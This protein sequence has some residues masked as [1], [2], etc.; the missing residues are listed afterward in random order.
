MQLPEIS[1]SQ[2]SENGIN[3]GRN[4]KI[5][6]GKMLKF[7]AV[8]KGPGKI[9][10]YLGCEGIGIYPLSSFMHSWM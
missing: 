7:D 2:P 10:C 4:S 3:G 8:M 9:Q 1:V 6:A 5:G